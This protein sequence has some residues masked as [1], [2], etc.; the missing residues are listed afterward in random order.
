[1]TSLALVL[2]AALLMGPP[3]EAPAPEV[4]RP[5]VT[6][7]QPQPGEPAIAPAEIETEAA[8]A[9]AEPVDP[10]DGPEP[11]GE[12]IGPSGEP[13][14]APSG[15]PG[16]APIEEPGPG[17]DA[18]AGEID[19]LP[20]WDS[21][22]EPVGSA[23]TPALDE[24]GVPI[25]RPPVDNSPPKGGGFYAGAG[26][27]FGVMVTKQLF[28]GLFCDDVYC[29]WRGNLDRVLGFGAIG[30]AGGGG[31]FDGRRAAYFELKDE[32][33]QKKLRGRQAA[34][35]TLFSLGMAGIL[36]DMVLYHLCYDGAIGPYT[37]LEGF[38]YTCEPVASVLVVDF[39]TI[40][41]AVGLGLG[42]SAQSQLR[43]RE[44]NNFELSFSPWGGRGTAGLS[45]SGRF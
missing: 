33:E 10:S 15:E 32:T 29:G 39:G 5:S 20:S 12:P 4:Q 27:V 19:T 18:R 45:V 11:S 16:V 37:N 43:H 30:L 13:G 36:T 14:D 28:M 24:W 3:S 26:A 31:W 17:P 41:S 2:G 38:S 40:M 42:M 8:D 35:W 25:D 23:E 6:P 34:G 22:A 9:P 1:M 7:I 21:P 44:R